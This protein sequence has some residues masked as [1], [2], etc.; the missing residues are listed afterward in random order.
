MKLSLGDTLQGLDRAISTL[1][2]AVDQE[3]YLRDRLFRDDSAWLKLLRYKLIPHLA[4][5]GCLVVAVAGG[6]NS[7]KSTLFNLLLR[8]QVSAI[9][10][11]A[12]ATR[13]P[14]LAAGP[15]RAAECR[16]GR[17]VPEFSVQPI[18]TPEDATNPAI[19]ADV[20][21]LAELPDL[22]DDRVYLDTPDVDSIDKRNWTLAEHVRAAGDVL[23]AVVTGEKYRDDR[24]V[25]FFREAAASGRHV[26]PLM[27]KANP[28]DNFAVARQQLK[29]FCQD[30]GIDTPCFVIP[31]D[32]TIAASLETRLAA[33]DGEDTLETYLAALDVAALKRTVYSDSVLRFC[34]EAANFMD[35]ADLVGEELRAVISAFHERVRDQ[36]KT[37]DPTP[38]TQIGGL[39]HEFV[40]KKR[41]PVR[42]LLG[43]TS[44]AIIRGA[45]SVALGLASA[46]KRRTTLQDAP[47]APTDVAI[48]EEHRASVRRITR[49]LAARL[50]ESSRNLRDAEAAMLQ[51][52]IKELDLDEAVEAVV[53]DAVAP[54][55]IS[56][57]FRAHAESLLETWWNDHKGRRR[58][59]EALDATVAVVP[60]AIAVPMSSLTGGWGVAETVL[61]VGG[62]AE[63]LVARGIEYQF[64]DAMFDFLSPWRREQQDRFSQAVNLHLLEPML[65]R[66]NAAAQAFDPDTLEQIRTALTACHQAGEE[67]DYG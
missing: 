54:E 49:E 67:E 9:V 50:V 10:N 48:L 53:R 5:G 61:M 27:N 37:F 18:E 58:I 29:D 43:R 45:G 22:P 52:G 7:G 3:P 57:T 32:F 41:G 28:V 34:A 47:A 4:D 6:T 12:A 25:A 44:S 65:T 16:E 59:L 46:V 2:I 17:L 36:V 62:L 23:V 55:N 56:E 31:H 38:G 1:E 64:G 19:D 30:T 26:I 35:R 51:R 63:Q 8:R 66:L 39:F 13:H 14:V 40:Q 15:R 11:T 20:L 24:V 60:T 33:L 42:R 21:L